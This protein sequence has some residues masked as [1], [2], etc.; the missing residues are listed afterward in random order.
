MVVVETPESLKICADAT[1]AGLR[2]DSFLAK[3]MPDYSRAWLTKLIKTGHVT[4][5]ASAAVKPAQTIVGNEIFL[6]SLPEKAAGT[7]E[8]QPIALEILFS[9]EHLAIINKPAG[10]VVHPGAGVKDGTLCNALLYHFPDMTIGNAER[11]GIV[12]RLD[13]ETSGIMVVAKTQAAHQILSA[14]FKERRIKK[15]YRAFCWGELAEDRLELK[16]GHVRHPY[17]RLKF[18]TKVSVPK[19]PS[20][21]VRLAHTDIAVV[22]RRFGITEVRATLHTGRTHQIRAHLADIDH[23]LLGDEL[24]GGKRSL[25][26][27]APD[28][29]RDAVEKLAGQAL[30]AESLEFAHPIKKTKLRFEAKLSERLSTLSRFF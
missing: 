23:P 22:N 24:Y 9:D 3:K 30:H 11:P 13:K 12:H 16:T 6:I 17:N 28:D 7:M 19:M 26:K 5:Q 25:L 20:A 1:D 21:N 14:D 4:S 10:L 8:P 18:F 15:I 27:S 2:L 29:L